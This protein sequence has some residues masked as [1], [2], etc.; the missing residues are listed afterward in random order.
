VLCFL[1]LNDPRPF[2]SSEVLVIVKLGFL[3]LGVGVGIVVAVAVL[4]WSWQ[5]AFLRRW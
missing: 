5:R 2:F 3:L 1:G 4:L